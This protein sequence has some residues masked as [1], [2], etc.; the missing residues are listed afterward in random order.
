MLNKMRTQKPYCFLALPLSLFE[1]VYHA[2]RV[3]ANDAGYQISSLDLVPELPGGSIQ[4][5]IIG[6]LAR[7]DCIIADV[8][9]QDPNVF[10]EIGLAQAMGKSILLIASDRNYRE[11]PFDVR[12]FR[13]ITYSINAR[14][15]KGLASKI[16]LSLHEF[17]QFPRQKVLYPKP[18]FSPPFFVD[19][20]LLG[21]SETENLCQELLAQM[22]FRRVDW[23]KG[24]PEFDL[25]AELPKKDPDGFE[26]REL[27][28]VSM[29]LRAPSE[30]LIDMAS[31][32]DYLV[33]SLSRYLDQNDERN[34]RQ[35]AAP[36]TL[37][38]VMLQ[39]G[40]D[41]QRFDTLRDRLEKR[42]NRKDKFG[43]NI[44]ARIWD[45]NYLTSLV[46]RFP[47]IGYKYFSDE[48]RIRSKTRKSYEELYRE[49]SSMSA[50][51]RKLNMVLEEEKNKR[52]RAERDSIW[53][54]I[55]FAAA[56]KIGNPIFAIETDLEP[57]LRRIREKR[58]DEAEEVIKNI[59]S[60]VEKA[61]AFV[62][63]FKSLAKAQDIKPITI[64]LKPILE[65][66]CK[67]LCNHEVKF[68]IKCPIDLKV[69]ADPDRLGECFD[70]LVMNA[71]HW[72]DKTEKTIEIE[73]TNPAPTPL[74]DFLDTTQRYIVIHVKDNGCGIAASEKNFVFDAFYTKHD[75][76]T[77]LGLALVRRIIDGHG[78]GIIES[79]IPGKGADFEIYLPLSPQTHLKKKAPI[80]KVRTSKK[81]E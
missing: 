65:D 6:E 28:I 30:L 18:Q 80:K 72:F 64:P 62:E 24:T 11:I 41:S 44:R 70:E 16:S 60:S 73:V 31:E 69:Q 63:Q 20:D 3:G 32:P 55:S 13:V 53:K 52:T 2:I 15:M 7:A 8:S 37:L 17:S 47:Q 58:Q 54:D 48:G 9:S 19:W 4:E 29:G 50:G 78:G 68:K 23:G 22:G 81:K 34:F 43:F 27:W 36:I 67:P 77:G 21:P 61:K 1:G 39:K 42:R 71:I 38:F 33:H 5:S 66:A 76:G 74:P 49:N 14:G 35:Y 56:H 40:Y 45:Q 26:Y 59:H 75:H 25:I 57:L 79:G 12:E 46:Q 10:F 51:L